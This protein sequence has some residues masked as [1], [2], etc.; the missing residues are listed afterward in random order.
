MLAKNLSRLGVLAGALSYSQS[1]HPTVYELPANVQQ[2]VELSQVQSLDYDHIKRKHVTDIYYRVQLGDTLS[3]ILNNRLQLKNIYG[4]RG[5][6]QSLEIPNQ[7]LL[8][9]GD[10][11]LIKTIKSSE[12]AAAEPAPPLK[13]HPSH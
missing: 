1:G 13:L 12:L 11:I 6:L 5:I 9:L 7:N 2:R 8:Y 10:S 4:P 3:S